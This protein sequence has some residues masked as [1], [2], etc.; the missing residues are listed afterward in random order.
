MIECTDCG[1]EVGEMDAFK[2]RCGS[3][4][5]RYL[6]KDF[7]PAETESQRLEGLRKDGT[8][9]QAAELEERKRKEREAIRKM[10]VTTESQLDNSSYSRLR[11][12]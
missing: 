4:H 5:S 7:D 2:G 10:I 11:K 6:I 3:C 8:K 12:H 9:R 1:R